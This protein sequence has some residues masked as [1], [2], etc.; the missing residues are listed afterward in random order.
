MQNDL[1]TFATAREESILKWAERN[2]EIQF[3]AATVCAAVYREQYPKQTPAPE[4]QAAYIIACLDLH[5]S[6]HLEI[7]KIMHRQKKT[8]PLYTLAK[9][10][11]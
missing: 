8:V 11:K 10:E 7:V 3:S 4:I 2:P 5:K 9:K 6:G 1:G